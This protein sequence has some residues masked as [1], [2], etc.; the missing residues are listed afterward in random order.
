MLRGVSF[1]AGA[2]E[3]LAITG[4]SGAGKSTLLHVLGGLEGA[5]DGLISF[6][7]FEVS[8]ASGERLAQY[9]DRVVGFVFQFHHLLPDL[10][11]IENV[12]LPLLIHRAGWRESFLRAEQALANVG[13]RERARHAVNQLSGGEQQ[14]A[15][16]ARA[17]VKRPR[18]ILAD[19]PTGNLDVDTGDEISAL[20]ASYCRAERALVI[21]AT[22]NERLALA[23]DRTLLLEGGKVTLMRNSGAGS[24]ES[25]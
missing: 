10:T 6:D 14:R 18:L 13:L 3:M 12:A 4:A 15:A 2:G 24:Q 7:D 20:L 5:D 1:D 21:V 23:C 19:E 25:E 22:H 8:R 9:R 16:L 11:A 17:L